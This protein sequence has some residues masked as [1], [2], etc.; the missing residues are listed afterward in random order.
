MDTLDV[1]NLN[2]TETWCCSCLLSC[3]GSPSLSPA[4]IPLWV[5][6]GST[7]VWAA[8]LRSTANECSSVTTLKMPLSVLWSNQSCAQQLLTSVP[9]FSQ[10]GWKAGLNIAAIK[11]PRHCYSV[12]QREAAVCTAQVSALGLPASTSIDLCGIDCPC[13]HCPG[14]LSNPGKATRSSSYPALPR[15]LLPVFFLFAIGN[16]PHR[17]PCGGFLAQE[18]AKSLLYKGPCCWATPPS[19]CASNVLPVDENGDFSLLKSEDI[20]LSS[21]ISWHVDC[22]FSKTVSKRYNNVK[23]MKLFFTFFFFPPNSY[24]DFF[25]F[26]AEEFGLVFL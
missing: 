9:C 13:W 7:W 5:L 24:R 21:L 23:N 15:S 22:F 20:R 14:K 1:D 25:Q 18:L 17:V 19:I 16:L 11:C 2:E 3:S 10:L 12:T 4:V 26:T 6:E 8:L